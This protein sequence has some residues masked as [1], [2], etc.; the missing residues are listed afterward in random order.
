MSLIGGQSPN[1]PHTQAGGQ[2]RH[3]EINVSWESGFFFFFLK[4]DFG[5][6]TN[7]VIFLS[8]TVM[9]QEFCFLKSGHSWFCVGM[10][11]LKSRLWMALAFQIILKR[12]WKLLF[13]FIF[14]GLRP[15]CLRLHITK[16][17]KSCKQKTK[18][19]PNNKNK[20]SLHPYQGKL[21]KPSG[22]N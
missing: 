3:A 16:K 1:K 8:I 22:G 17:S 6:K 15:L 2:G 14:S 13:Y 9:Q 4:R 7:W 18:K 20:L 5:K 12:A 11:W 10:T 19:N 21:Q